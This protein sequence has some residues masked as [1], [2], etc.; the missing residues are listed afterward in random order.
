MSCIITE[1]YY[2]LFMF[3]ISSLFDL[4][5]R[6]LGHHIEIQSDLVML[7]KPLLGAFFVFS[8]F[9]VATVLRNSSCIFNLNS[10][11]F[12]KPIWC[13]CRRCGDRLIGGLLW[14]DYC[15]RKG[16]ECWV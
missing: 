13:I 14:Y 8:F 7:W 1:V 15:F 9:E 3:N 4:F 10:Y 16:T 11:R 5:V 2:K 12:L 6:G